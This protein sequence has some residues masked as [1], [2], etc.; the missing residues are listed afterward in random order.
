MSSAGH[1]AP[2]VV[3]ED[4]NVHEIGQPGPLLGGFSEATWEDSSVPVAAG[5]TLF[6]Y[7]DGVTDT[8][9]EQ[10]RFGSARLRSVLSGQA[11]RPP[12]E[13]LR[14][15]EIALDE[16]QVVGLTDDTGAV[17]LRPSPVPARGTGSGKLG[18]AVSTR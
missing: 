3:Q 11:G 9:G 18:G 16:F 7:T 17:A 8:R 6:M 14:E 1:P 5:D 15:L 10:E 2:L 12:A 4:G 13:L